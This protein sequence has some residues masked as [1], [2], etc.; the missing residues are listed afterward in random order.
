MDDLVIVGRRR[1]VSGRSRDW[2]ACLASDEQMADGH[3]VIRASS[4]QLP[5][6]SDSATHPPKAPT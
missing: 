3:K 5:A 4:V 2:L 6:A 1:A